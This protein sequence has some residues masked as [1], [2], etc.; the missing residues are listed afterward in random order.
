MPAK[1]EIGK[2]CCNCIG[3]HQPTDRYGRNGL[4][5][6]Q[7]DCGSRDENEILK[8]DND[9][10]GQGIYNFFKWVSTKDR[11]P[12]LNKDVLIRE[13]HDLYGIIYIVA[14]LKNFDGILHWTSSGFGCMA[15]S[16]KICVI[17]HWAEIPEEPV[18]D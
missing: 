3:Y 1:I 8:P 4:P 10:P 11:M 17:T 12:E 14:R 16:K 18:D 5:Y 9:C 15:D 13:K 7:L 6:C 2:C